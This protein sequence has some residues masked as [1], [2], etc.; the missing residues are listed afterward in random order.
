MIYFSHYCPT[1][2][3]SLKTEPYIEDNLVMDE[4]PNIMIVGK[5]KTFGS[6][7]LKVEGR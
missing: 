6:R 3:F 5:A 7:L 1:A 2:P 4:I